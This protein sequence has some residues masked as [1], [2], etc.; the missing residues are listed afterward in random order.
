MKDD[1]G[2]FHTYPYKEKDKN[3]WFEDDI[4]VSDE[5]CPPPQSNGRS[6]TLWTNRHQSNELF[7]GNKK[8]KLDGATQKER[9][10]D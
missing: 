7:E 4:V 6:Y 2:R 1:S 8:R 10:T 5:T 9:R 3:I